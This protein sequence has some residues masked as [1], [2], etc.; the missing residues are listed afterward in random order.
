MATDRRRDADWYEQELKRHELAAARRLT[1]VLPA[2]QSADQPPRPAQLGEARRVM[3]RSLRDLARLRLSLEGEIE[4]LQ[5][6]ERPAP[7]AD[8]ASAGNGGRRGRPQP[9]GRRRLHPEVPR[10]YAARNAIDDVI[11]RWER[12]RDQLAAASGK[13]PAPAGKRPPA[14]GKR[15]PPTPPGHRPART[16]R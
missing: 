5:G 7:G 11:E 12:R 2:D 9:P 4:R 3:E 6:R 8:A 13:R 10:Y 14:A 16:R 15:Q 1:T